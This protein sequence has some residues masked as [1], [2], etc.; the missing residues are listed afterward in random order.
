MSTKQQNSEAREELLVQ[1]EEQIEKLL[2]ESG[3]MALDYLKNRTPE[4]VQDKGYKDVVT[5]A[6]LAIDAF[7]RKRFAELQPK[8]NLWTEEEGMKNNGSRF[9]WV[10]DPIDGT[11]NFSR[12]IPL[13]G[14]SIAVLE[15]P[16]PDFRKPICGG[17]FL[18]ALNELY[19]A[20]THRGARCNGNP[21]QVSDISNPEEALISNGDFNVGNAEKIN[22]WNL[23]N[24]EKQAEHLRRVKCL[25]SAVVESAL[26]ASGRLDAYAMT[27]SYPW[28]IA[29][30]IILVEEAG[31]KCTQL[32]GKDTR[33]RPHADILFSNGILHDQII[34]FLN[35]E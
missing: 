16:S 11:V 9:T 33:I 23:K 22:A 15:G 17:I 4:S 32:N 7:L 10:A 30:G 3:Q 8:W 14:I 2:R 13:W 24:F 34:N 6:D 19:I 20:S 29:A 31:G 35:E 25:G 26:V 18:P 21:I 5:Q 28:D 1:L 12:G 27:V